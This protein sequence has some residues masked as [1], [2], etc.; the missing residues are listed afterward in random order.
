MDETLPMGNQSLISFDADQTLFDFERVM[1]QALSVVAEHIY[2][3]YSIRVSVKELKDRRDRIASKATASTP[4]LELRRLS[5]QEI[6]EEYGVTT[7]GAI[8]AAMGLFE[9]IRFGQVYLYEDTIPALSTLAEKLPL[10][11]LTNGNS[12]AAQAQIDEYFTYSVLAEDVG[13]KKPDRRIFDSLLNEA[14][15]RANQLMHVGD[16]LETDVQGAL[17]AGAT[18]VYLN[19]NT[20]PNKTAITP[21]YEICELTE[22]LAIVD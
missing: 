20:I 8:N 14:G 10:A 13:Y 5:F 9:E 11:L 19:R 2:D 21:H 22:L 3:R 6:L 1:Y 17:N 12:T 18:S 4:M 16:S 15:L 7:P